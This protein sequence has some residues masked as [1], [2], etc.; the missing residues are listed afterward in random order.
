MNSV[1]IGMKLTALS[2]VNGKLNAM[3]WAFS[4]VS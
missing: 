2:L 1:R 3:V 4:M